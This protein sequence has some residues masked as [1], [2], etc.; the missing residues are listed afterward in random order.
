M[1]EEPPPSRALPAQQRGD[2]GVTA[3]AAAVDEQPDVVGDVMS[4]Q[5]EA[6]E[7]DPLPRLSLGKDVEHPFEPTHPRCAEGTIAVEDEEGR[8]SGHDSMLR[9]ALP[10]DSEGRYSLI[11]GIVRQAPDSCTM[12]ARTQESS[13]SVS[14]L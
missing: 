11:A 7:I 9:G 10:E 3:V 13:D 12:P 5:A 4:A 14:A 8:L 2:G 1:P 6:V